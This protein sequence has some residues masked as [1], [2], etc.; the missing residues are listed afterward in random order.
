MADRIAVV[1]GATGTLGREL[2][3]LLAGQ[4]L[5]VA[6]VSRSGEAV[7]A[8]EA[9]SVS[10]DLAA[11]ES[12]AAIRSALPLGEVA[13]AV[14]AVGLPPAPN[15]M[16]VDA[17]MLG[18]AVN[19]KA[20]GMLRL[21]RALDERIVSGSRVVAVG[22]HLGFEPSEHAPL[23]GVANAALANLV[24]QLEAPLRRRGATIGLVAPAYFD[25]P[26]TDR[27]IAS[28]A[29]ATGRS[30]EDVRAELAPGGR[31]STAADV[32]ASILA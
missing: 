14:H 21:L 7:G 15:V 32:A 8:G 24:G 16:Q 11:T 29:A 19:I 13:W 26:R 3:R 5:A 2:V 10:A 23:A 1:T 4:G 28:R 9:V 17:D 22:G 12:I 30:P 18:A 27:M 20:G 25:S 31:M 6:A